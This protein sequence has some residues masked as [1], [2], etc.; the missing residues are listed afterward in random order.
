MQLTSAAESGREILLELDSDPLPD[1]EPDP[2]PESDPDPDS[3]KLICTFISS[4]TCCNVGVL[5]VFGS[6]Q[7]TSVEESGR[8]ILLL[9]LDAGI[10]TD[11]G[12]I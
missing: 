12:E 11:P 3:S 1:P 2:D 9:E 6:D 8:E 7:V 10:G 5:P 4:G